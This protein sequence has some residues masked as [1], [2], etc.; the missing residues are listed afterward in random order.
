MTRQGT[1][2]DEREMKQ[3]GKTPLKGILLRADLYGYFYSVCIYSLL[4][5]PQGSQSQPVFHSLS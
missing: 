5:A 3:V 2:L 1:P 4:L